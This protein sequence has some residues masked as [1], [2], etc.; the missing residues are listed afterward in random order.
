MQICTSPITVCGQIDLDGR[1]E[2]KWS[3][4]EHFKNES[5]ICIR[6]GQTMKEVNGFTCTMSVIK[7]LLTTQIFV[8]KPPEMGPQC[9]YKFVRI[10]YW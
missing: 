1:M 4:G 8:Y 3:K 2:A 6:V 7:Q 5:N 9:K 10:R